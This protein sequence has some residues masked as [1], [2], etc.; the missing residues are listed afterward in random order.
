[1]DRIELTT[2]IFITIISSLLIFGSTL[3]NFEI[4]AINSTINQQTSDIVDIG[5]RLIHHCKSI[6]IESLDLA[7][8][9]INLVL[10]LSLIHI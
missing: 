6:V 3:S 1:M 2:L 4:E 9:S 5:Y 8:Q 10:D 7:K